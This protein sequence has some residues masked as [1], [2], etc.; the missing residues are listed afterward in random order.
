MYWEKLGETFK[1]KSR[2]LCLPH[3]KKVA[4]CNTLGLV[5]SDIGCCKI[6]YVFCSLHF[7]VFPRSQYSSF[8]YQYLMFSFLHQLQTILESLPKKK[9]SFFTSDHLIF[10]FYISS[11]K[12]MKPRFPVSKNYL[13]LF[14]FFLGPFKGPPKISQKSKFVMYTPTFYF[15]C[16]QWWCGGWEK[17]RHTAG[18][19]VLCNLM[20]Y[21][22]NNLVWDMGL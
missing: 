2:S 14:C 16:V 10:V 20:S 22:L 15:S 8:S 11:K 7:Y 3:K 6:V 17:V 4:M 5:G 13:C 19:Q 21:I 18:K 9:M 12:S 1:K